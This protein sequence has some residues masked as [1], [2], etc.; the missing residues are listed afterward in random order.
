M[1]DI[2]AQKALQVEPV[3]VWGDAL[4]G[5][6][7]YIFGDDLSRAIAMIGDYTPNGMEVYNL[8][9]GVGVSLADDIQSI[10]LYTQTPLKIE[11]VKSN[12]TSSIKRIVLD[13]DKFTRKTG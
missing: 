11:T 3:P 6:R 13:M 7:D 10:N 2:F 9:T 5:V 4:D 1:V 12:A 8:G